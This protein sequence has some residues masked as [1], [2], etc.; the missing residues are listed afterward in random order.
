[1][2]EGIQ[3]DSNFP[4]QSAISTLLSRASITEK[5]R[6]RSGADHSFYRKPGQLQDRQRMRPKTLGHQPSVA[7]RR[8]HAIRR[9]NLR[10]V[11]NRIQVP[12]TPHHFAIPLSFRPFPYSGHSLRMV[13][14][15]VILMNRDDHAG[16]I[17]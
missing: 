1:M 17:H 3:P 10:G 14:E 16:N 5:L 6:T 2:D 9:K 12:P 15:V 13:R 7:M 4:A 8:V 11:F